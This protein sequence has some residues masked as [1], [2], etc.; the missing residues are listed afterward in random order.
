MDIAVTLKTEKDDGDPRLE[1]HTI[2]VVQ[3]L[4]EGGGVWPERYGSRDQAAAFLR[5]LKA[6][7]VMLDRHDIEVPAL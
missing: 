5:G 1:I 7:F 4:L 6:A 3:L 2:E